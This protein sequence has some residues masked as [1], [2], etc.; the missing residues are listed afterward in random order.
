MKWFAA[1]LI[2]LLVVG[3]SKPESSH[4]EASGKPEAGASSQLKASGAAEPVTN[5][6]EG[7]AVGRYQG[8]VP[9]THGE[10][11]ELELR[12]D[13]SAILTFRGGAKPSVLKGTWKVSTN[14]VDI[15]FIKTDGK[16]EVQRYLFAMN[17]EGNALSGNAQKLGTQGPML[18][19]KKQ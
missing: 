11:A 7:A 15:L 12:V 9:G 5:L 1:V 18:S 16:P 19:L 4:P 6:T 8:I 3:C 2:P 13:K 14:T 10:S 17:E